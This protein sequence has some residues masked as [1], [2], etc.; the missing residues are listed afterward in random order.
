MAPKR[1]AAAAAATD[2]SRAARRCRRA[3]RLA[4]PAEPGQLIDGLPVFGPP[5]FLQCMREALPPELNLRIVALSR[6]N[7]LLEMRAWSRG[8][9][10][11]CMEEL[12]AG[13]EELRVF[14]APHGAAPD[15]RDPAAL[16]RLL[17]AAPNLR[18]V[19]MR[20]LSAA[21]LIRE[22]GLAGR[23]VN[24]AVTEPNEKSVV[25]TLSQE[26]WDALEPLKPRL[27]SLSIGIGYSIVKDTAPPAPVRIGTFP[28]VHT[29]R[30]AGV[31]CADAVAAFPAARSLRLVRTYYRRDRVDLSP[32]LAGV[33]T[34]EEFEA[35]GLEPES[36]RWLPAGARVLRLGLVD[37]TL[38]NLPRFERLERF[39]AK[40]DYVSNLGVLVDALARPDRLRW[41]AATPLA[42][43]D[44][45]EDFCR[46][47]KR[48]EGLEALDAAIDTRSGY[49]GEKRTELILR[50]LPRS[51]R[52]LRIT[53]PATGGDA[54][55]TAWKAS[56]LFARLPELRE[57]WFGG[58]ATFL[59]MDPQGVPELCVSQDRRTRRFDRTL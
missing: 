28:R 15:P 22:A 24:L 11:A 12:A 21:A 13:R 23:A 32:S 57:V 30:L 56:E 25:V 5:T 4:E 42:R 37:P 45:V 7:S 3:A 43:A 55:R 27:E 31:A 34:L 54:L 58:E 26:F 41:L 2:A 18:I 6:P 47:L 14:A 16:R 48:L 17:A 35:D 9:R 50:A 52:Y 29:V 46:A 10:A 36:L 51:L 8:M 33:S 1:A 40:N 19:G 39:E 49:L 44:N 38:G 53:V 59:R 20:G